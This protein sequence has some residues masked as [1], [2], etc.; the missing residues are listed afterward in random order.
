MYTIKGLCIG[1]IF[2]LI[3]VSELGGCCL[4]VKCIVPQGK[5][6][7]F[8]IEGCLLDS[9][10]SLAIETQTIITSYAYPS[11]YNT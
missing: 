6:K 1:C 7:P 10:L 9:K 5:F 11:A 3:L 4:C 8:L 2:F